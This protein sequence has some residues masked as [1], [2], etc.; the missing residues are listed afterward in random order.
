MT[1]NI[2][3]SFVSS[4]QIEAGLEEPVFSETILADVSSWAAVKY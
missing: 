3:F 4:K 2:Q 1:F